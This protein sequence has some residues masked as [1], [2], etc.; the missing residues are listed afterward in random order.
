MKRAKNFKTSVNN[1]VSSSVGRSVE[2]EISSTHSKP[3]SQIGSE[4]KRRFGSSVDGMKGAAQNCQNDLS[5]SFVV[6]CGRSG[7]TSG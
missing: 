4:R 2:G 6:V 7:E 1:A 5:S 3:G